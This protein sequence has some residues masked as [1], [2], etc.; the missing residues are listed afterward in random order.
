MESLFFW[1]G[2]I[3]VIISVSYVVYYFFFRKKSTVTVKKTEE[4]KEKGKTTTEKQVWHTSPALAYAI[5]LIAFLCGFYYFW[6]PTPPEQVKSSTT[7]IYQTHKEWRPHRIDVTPNS[8]KTLYVV[9][10]S[11]KIQPHCRIQYD[12]GSGW[13]KN[14]PGKVNKRSM[15]AGN[16]FFRGDGESGTVD[17]WIYS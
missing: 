16:Y 5:L 2:F 4:K 14:W 11:I 15:T 6:N 12:N 1:L 10:D 7:I 3:I 17:V 9:G 13:R 8:T